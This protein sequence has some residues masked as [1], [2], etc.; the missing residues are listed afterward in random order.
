[1]LQEQ[2]ILAILEDKA[3]NIWVGTLNGAVKIREQTFQEFKQKDG[4][5]TNLI[6]FIYEDSQG[7]LWFST[8]G[9]GVTKYKD[10]KFTVYTTSNGLAHKALSCIYEDEDAVVLQTI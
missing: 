7:N 6:N 1:M 10:H 4:L 8:I 2:D 5:A 3:G 9:G